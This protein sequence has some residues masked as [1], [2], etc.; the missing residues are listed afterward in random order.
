MLNLPSSGLPLEDKT[1]CYAS[2]GALVFNFQSLEAE[3]IQLLCEMIDSRSENLPRILTS[4]LSFRR[5]I[6][7]LG[8]LA[9]EKLKDRSDLNDRL[10]AVLSKALE[11]EGERNRYVHSH[12]DLMEWNFLDQVRFGQEKHHVKYGNG[13]RVSRETFDPKKIDV[14][15]AGIADAISALLE[16]SHEI[17]MHLYPDRFGPENE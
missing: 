3:L 14:I 9:F 8:S 5:I 10:Q 12:Y 15:C 13:Y 1:H 7:A 4:S 6:D 17:E 16:V 11:L 2:M